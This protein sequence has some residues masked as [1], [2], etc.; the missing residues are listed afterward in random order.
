MSQAAILMNALAETLES[1]AFFIAPEEALHLTIGGHPL[2]FLLIE[3]DGD[4][5]LLISSPLGRLPARQTA[6]RWRVVQDLMRE[7]L[8]W[9]GT[10]GGVLALEAE[11][12]AVF[13]QK[14]WFLNLPPAPQDFV[15]EIARFLTI[16]RDWSS[17]LS[18]ENTPETIPDFALK[19]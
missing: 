19:V 13:L 2:S 18:A 17:R 9:Q 14:R 11:T 4:E 8:Q 12:D 3:D 10:D 6:F 7:N 15:D 1:P 5:I 16:A